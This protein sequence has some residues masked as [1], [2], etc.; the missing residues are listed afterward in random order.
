M[1]KEEFKEIRLKNKMTQSDL[2]T[3]I[4]VKR[5]TIGCYERGTRRISK[6]IEKLI[7]SIEIVGERIL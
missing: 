1:T 7:L 5:Q 3:I 6:P 2:A 4:G